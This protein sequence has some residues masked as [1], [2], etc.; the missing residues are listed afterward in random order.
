MPPVPVGCCWW[1]SRFHCL[2]INDRN[3][4]TSDFH[5]ALRRLTEDTPKSNSRCARSAACA[6]SARLPFYGLYAR[7]PTGREVPT[8]H[9]D[10]QIVLEPGSQATPAEFANGRRRSISPTTYPCRGFEHRQVEALGTVIPKP[11]RVPEEG[12]DLD[13]APESRS[14]AT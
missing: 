1:N 2:L 5:V 3:R 12:A 7:A 14:S 4:Q 8:H 10:I 6:S 9:P 11:R 13:P